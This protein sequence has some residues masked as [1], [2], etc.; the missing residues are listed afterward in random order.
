MKYM[1]SKKQYINEIL[2]IILK[3]RKK[4]QCY[5][6][7]FAGGMNVIEHVDGNRIAND[8]N[9]YIIKLYQ[10]IVYDNWIPPDEISFEEYNHIKDF[11]ELYQH[12]PQLI[13]FVGIG[14]SFGGK[15]FGGYARSN[16]ENGI[17][18]NHCLES[19][20]SILKQKDKLYGTWFSFGSYNKLNIPK[21]SIIYCDIPYQDTT[22]YKSNID[23]DKFWNWARDKSKDGHKVFI[24]EKRLLMILNAFGKQMPKRL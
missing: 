16:T 6:E 1:G 23:Y 20:K 15:W 12:V 11:R 21:E 18:R 8:I 14:C 24:S 5:V 4:H 9:Y 22:K 10:S 2:P 19:K 17:P 3:D 13:G 7:P